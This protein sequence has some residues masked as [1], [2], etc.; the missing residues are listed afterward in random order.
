VPTGKPAAEQAAAEQAA[1][2]QAAA[3]PSNRIYL[4]KI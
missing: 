4:L 3:E 2:E 1:A